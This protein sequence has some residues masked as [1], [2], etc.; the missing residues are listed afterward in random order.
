MTAEQEIGDDQTT[1]L[2]FFTEDGWFPEQQADGILG[3]RYKG[4]TGSW[5]CFAEARR[6]PGQF[7][8]YSVQPE[9]VPD[10]DMLRMAELITWINES[11]LVGNF[12]L[13]MS[14]GQVRFKTSILLDAEPLTVALLRPMVY[15][16]VTSM[17]RCRPALLA[18][19]ETTE[20][21][22]TIAANLVT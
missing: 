19:L 6:P 16:N 5:E 3:M 13:D 21:P 17:D 18:V 22:V 8:F 15:L 20:K 2:D 9:L 14:L 7:M 11:L 12:E 10:D 1:M 4:Q